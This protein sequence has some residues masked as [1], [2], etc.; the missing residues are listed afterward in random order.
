MDASSTRTA[1][2]RV[3]VSCWYALFINVIPGFMLALKLWV[4]AQDTEGQEAFLVMPSWYVIMYLCVLAA[5]VFV[6]PSAFARSRV[7]GFV[8]LLAMLLS[9]AGMLPVIFGPRL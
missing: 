3:L 4:R 8:V 7:L 2:L 5:G 6:V 1:N 9:F